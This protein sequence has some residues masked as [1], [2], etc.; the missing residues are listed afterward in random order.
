VVRVAAGKSA[1]LAIDRHAEC[2]NAG[3]AARTG[4]GPKV[5]YCNPTEG[6]TIVEWIAGRTNV[7]TDLDDSVQLARIAATCRRLHQGPRFAN[8]FDMFV[9]QREYLAVVLE[10]GYRLPARY[11]DFMP[12]TERMR[13]ALTAQ[14]VDTV[15]CH[16]DLLAGNI[17]DDGD[18]MWFI[19]YEYA[20]NNDPCFELGNIWS[21]ST[22]PCE[23]LEQLVTS[24]Y[25]YL[26]P[27]KVARARLL[28]LMS[29]YGWMLW[30]SIQAA[31]SEVDFDFWSW[32]MEKYERA[33]V[34]F[35]GP[36]FSQL[37]ADVQRPDQ[38]RGGQGSD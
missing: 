37:I 32:G 22:L 14:R 6:I 11:L 25:G 33:I 34:E 36:E 24:Y 26:S 12:R 13:A 29:K 20:G 5:F 15:P 16:N 21:E 7:A 9:I 23:R 8:D 31:V 3:A 28:A 2:H 19:D 1:L 35:D 18:R 38:P 17:M 30:A 10:H 4:V 27:A